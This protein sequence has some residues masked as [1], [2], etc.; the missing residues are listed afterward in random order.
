MKLK[1]LGIINQD[2]LFL[3]INKMSSKDKENFLDQLLIQA[4]S[5]FSIYIRTTGNSDL[6]F[7]DPEKYEK[8]SKE[9]Y[10]KYIDEFIEKYNN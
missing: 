4:E 6:L 9:F 1:I 8:L 10:V 7:V 2:K 3:L 5:A